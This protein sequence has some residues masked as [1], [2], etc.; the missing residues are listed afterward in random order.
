MLSKKTNYRLVVCF[1]LVQAVAVCVVLGLFLVDFAASFALT[2]ERPSVE[3]MLLILVNLNVLLLLL[4]N[5]K[6]HPPKD[7]E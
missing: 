3:G 6:Q 5:I 7:G 1:V 2:K 4:L